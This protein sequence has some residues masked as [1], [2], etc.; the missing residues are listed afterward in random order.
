LL[1][2]SFSLDDLNIDNQKNKL[3]QK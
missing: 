3:N 2:N 1:E